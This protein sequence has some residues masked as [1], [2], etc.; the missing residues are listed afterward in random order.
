MEPATEDLLLDFEGMSPEDYA[1]LY[2]CDPCYDR[3]PRLPGDGYLFYNFGVEGYDKSFL[4][5]FIP[6]IDRTIAEE[7]QSLQ[8]REN[9]ALLLELCKEIISG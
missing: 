6:A 1:A 7:T 5:K 3:S 9:L 8:D 2:G 4:E